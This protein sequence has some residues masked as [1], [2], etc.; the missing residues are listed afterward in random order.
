[1]ARWSM[2]QTKVH[3]VRPRY[4]LRQP[5]ADEGFPTLADFPKYLYRHRG[6]RLTSEHLRKELPEELR[7]RPP[8]AL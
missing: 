5:L 1:M 4:R 8:A 3:K 2:R 6:G 7:V